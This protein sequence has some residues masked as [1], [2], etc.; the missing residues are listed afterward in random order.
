MKVTHRMAWTMIDYRDT[1]S[2]C[3]TE[4]VLNLWKAA[5]YGT[6]TP[7]LMVSIP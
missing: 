5:G 2:D 4:R 7:K 6:K 3:V 1:L